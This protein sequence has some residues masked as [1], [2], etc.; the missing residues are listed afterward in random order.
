MR[1]TRRTVIGT[2]GVARRR[3]LVP[4]SPSQ[5]TIECVE[6]RTAVTD[7]SATGIGEDSL[8]AL[9]TLR[10][11]LWPLSTTLRPWSAREFK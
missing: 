5:W 6:R 9:S 4:V 8:A 10:P 3:W 7:R 1:F 2:P 11:R